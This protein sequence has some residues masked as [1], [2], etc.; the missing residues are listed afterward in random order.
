[1]SEAPWRQD[2]PIYRQLRD[3]L[4]A[5]I[6][7]GS[8]REGERLPSVR[9]L[10]AAWGLNPITVLRGCQPLLAAGVIE[11]H[12]GRGLFVRAGASA[13]L[14]AEEQRRFLESEWP[15]IRAHIERLGLSS[16]Q[17]LEIAALTVP[18]SAPAGKSGPSL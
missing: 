7:A 15:G 8:L 11:K 2:Q 6:L 17:L 3:R 18:A 12:R 14:R 4:V 5:Q 16:P 13:V 1:M 9:Q 10:A